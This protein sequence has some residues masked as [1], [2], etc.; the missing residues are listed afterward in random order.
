MYRRGGRIEIDSY[1]DADFGED[2]D[3]IKSVTGQLHFM[4][5]C[6]ISWSSKMQSIV[7]TS[8]AEAEYVA[9]SEAVRETSWLR[10]VLAEIGYEQKESTRVRCDNQ[11]AI[12]L[13]ENPIQHKRTKHIDIK[14]HYVREIVANKEVSVEYI[15]TTN[16]LADIMTKGLNGPTHRRLVGMISMG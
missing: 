10:Q 2:L 5:G 7:A 6:L 15:N 16:M 9:L 8:T 11:I 1:S 4:G 12:G 13:A 14:Y 3:S